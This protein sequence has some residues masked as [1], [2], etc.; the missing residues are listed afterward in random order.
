M[1]IQFPADPGSQNP[2]NTFGP[3]STPVAN[4]VNTI[5]YF[6]DGEKWNANA[7]SALK[8][9]YV[10]IKGDNMTGNLTLGGDK[11]ELNATTGNITASGNITGDGSITAA[12]GDFVVNDEGSF[13]AKVDI[14]R[15]EGSTALAIFSQDDIATPTIEAKSDG[16]IITTGD[17]Q[18]ASQNNGPLAGFKNKLIN[19]DFRVTQRGSVFS[20][21]DNNTPNVIYTL[22]GWSCSNRGVIAT[23]QQDLQT[24]GAMASR[25]GLRTNISNGGGGPENYITIMQK[26]EDCTTVQGEFTLSFKAKASKAMSIGIEL[27][28][29]YGAGGSSTDMALVT[30]K[31][32]LTTSFE[33]YTVTG[34]MPSLSGKTF[35]SDTGSIGLLFWMSAGTD[36]NSRASNIGLQTGTVDIADV[37]LEPGSVATPFEHRP[38]AMELAMCQRYFYRMNVEPMEDR[39]FAK[40]P[41]NF[42]GAPPNSSMNSY[43]AFPVTMRVAPTIDVKISSDN[44]QRATASLMGV[45][46]K[47][48]DNV[49]NAT[50]SVS[51]YFANAEL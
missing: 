34:T 8:A 1:A 24:P 47:F 25:Y 17:V 12:D 44:L 9:T 10:A 18:M 16:K 15:S 37:Q 7:D 6:W 43:E 28:R 27:T 26:I 13:G 38:I 45:G 11:V 20:I 39:N 5:V 49:N 4:T 31:I 42:G 32:D 3:D 30:E 29:S 19:S 35:G 40:S 22:D 2:P 21:P 50:A 23:V 36:Y 14:K 48:T 51:G 33:Q 41:Y 46:F